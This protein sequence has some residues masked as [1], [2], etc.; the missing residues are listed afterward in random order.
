MSKATATRIARTFEVFDSYAK[1]DKKGNKVFVPAEVMKKGEITP[2]QNR[3]ARPCR[4]CHK[5]MMVAAGQV[6]YY[7][8]EC[9]KRKRSLR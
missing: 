5:P 8:S 9:R 1:I 3:E 6:A 7:H 4:F 2:A